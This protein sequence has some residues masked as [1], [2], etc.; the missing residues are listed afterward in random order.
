[1]A[2]PRTVPVVLPDARCLL[3][4]SLRIGTDLGYEVPTIPEGKPN[5]DHR[6]VDFRRA[7]LGM[8]LRDGLH[9]PDGFC[10]GSS[11]FADRYSSK[12]VELAR[13]ERI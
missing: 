9:L 6:S 12:A 1:M 4:C 11:P 13:I 7:N 2:E 3:G 5:Q 10:R 8:G